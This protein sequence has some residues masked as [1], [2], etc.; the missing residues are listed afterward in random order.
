MTT[1]KLL[2]WAA[3][4]AYLFAAL[5]LLDYAAYLSY[6]RKL[7]PQTFSGRELPELE[8]QLGLPFTPEKRSSFLNFP[9]KKAPGVFRIG[10]FGD[11]FTY[12]EETGPDYDYPG[13]LAALFRKA[14]YRNVEVLNFGKQYTGFHQAFLAWEALGEKYG[15]DY[16]VLWPAGFN[17][18]SLV[19]DLKFN[20]TCDRGY[21]SCMPQYLHARYTLAG[22]GVELKV[23][24]GRTE[25]ERV[26]AYFSFIPSF[27]NLRYD[28][29][30]PAFLR[31]P[32]AALAPA[33]VMANPFYYQKD[34]AAEQRELTRRLLLKMA[35]GA[36]SVAVISRDPE[37]AA[38][39]GSLGA[40][41]LFSDTLPQV[42]GFPYTAFNGHNSPA[43]NYLVARRL[44]DLLT[45]EPPARLG[46][47]G[48]SDAPSQGGT[49]GSGEP[50]SGYRSLAVELGGVPLGRFYDSARPPQDYCRPGNCRP[51]PGTFSG[52]VSLLALKDQRTPLVDAVFLPLNFKLTDLKE[53]SLRLNGLPIGEVR[54]A[55][56]G[57]NFGVAT[58]DGSLSWQGPSLLLSPA[59][60][61]RAPGAAAPG[62]VMLGGQE[63]LRADPAQGPRLRLTP[64]RPFFTLKGDGAVLADQESLGAAGKVFLALEDAS[65]RKN[66]V[67]IADWKK[68][69]LNLPSR[70]GGWNKVPLPA[71]K[72]H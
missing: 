67:H 17:A 72:G 58:V 48:F 5:A 61:G 63:V 70:T 64:P 20:H 6:R 69:R 33:R 71:R 40:K 68:T 50:L 46:A 26:D 57:L 45:G 55:A 27:Q 29:E 32:L 30:A 36:P 44:F 42:P 11:S 22:P 7:L 3:Y 39:A 10:C 14:G 19:R 47:L 25:K 21:L 23:P 51:I 15:L 53:L 8:K 28:L 2:Y 60:K 37:V 52:V 41:N 62:P 24:P 56:K 16:A 13:V 9:E 31:A 12:G 65:G 54:L 4:L 35:A 1:R 38:L 49:A 59:G 43:G 34:P 66:L 18:L